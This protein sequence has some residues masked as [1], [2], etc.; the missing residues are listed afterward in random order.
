LAKLNDRHIGFRTSWNN[1]LTIYR[2]KHEV[3]PLDLTLAESQA[4]ISK[5]NFN[6]IDVERGGYNYGNKW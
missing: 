6:S 3:L 4:V 2:Y 1:N 5:I